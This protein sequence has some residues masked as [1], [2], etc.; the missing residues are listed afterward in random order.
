LVPDSGL[1]LSAWPLAEGVRHLNHGS[2]GSSPRA[3]LAAQVELRAEMDADP[4]RWFRG[5]PDRVAE[6]RVEVASSLGVTDDELAFVPNASAGVSA[7]LRGLAL[8]PG[9]EIVLT[10]HA[11]GAV[12][13]AAARVAEA[14]G[15]RVRT[16]SV[17]LDATAEA[18][19][20]AIAAVLGAR[21]A[22][23]IVDQVSSP[24]ARAL[25]VE[26]ITR[27]AHRAGVPVLVDAAHAPG[28]FADPVRRCGP[29][30]FWVGNLHKWACAP[31]GTAVLVAREPWAQDLYPVIDSWGTPDA[32]PRRFDRQGTVDL[33]AWLTAP[34]AFEFIE[35][36]VGWDALRASA[37]RLADLG[38]VRLAEALGGDV[39]EV[40]ALPAPLMRL[41]P[42]PDGLVTDQEQAHALQHRIA[43]ETRCEIAVT[44]WGGRGYIRLSTHA[45]NTIDDIDQLA[46]L[47]PATL[48]AAI[49]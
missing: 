34:F 26:L 4:D 10:D 47:L 25:P 13:M 12:A 38:Q 11:Y 22:L 14:A 7:V 3:V 46:A 30:D 36:A 16:V 31:R 41:V 27:E 43:D 49:R 48:A 6:A 42:L 2:F 9:A 29:V 33:T 1:P 35:R 15:A 37:A 39:S 21:T 23:L 20:A 45:Y 19:T 44:T 24:T 8:R 18:A 17:P 5:L 40:C 28:M 32:Y